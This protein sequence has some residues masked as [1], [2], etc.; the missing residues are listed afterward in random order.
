MDDSEQPVRRPTR[1]C[2]GCRPRLCA[3][4][5][6]R[7]RCPPWPRTGRS[8]PRRAAAP[9]KPIEGIRIDSVLDPGLG[10]S[11]EHLVQVYPGSRRGSPCRRP[12]RRIVGGRRLDSPVRQPVGKQPAR[13]FGAVDPSRS[14]DF[15]HL[16]QQFAL[17]TPGSPAGARCGRHR[18][19]SSRSS[20]DQ[21]QQYVQVAHDQ[22]GQA[23]EVAYSVFE[24]IRVS[25]ASKEDFDQMDGPHSKGSGK[26]RRLTLVETDRPGSRAPNARASSSPAWRPELRP[27]NSPAS[28]CSRLSRSPREGGRPAAPAR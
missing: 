11:I 10:D 9:T 16:V 15:I 3:P 6:V 21:V 25:R 20:F 4:G 17:Q 14:G 24:H 13:Q 18:S 8:G 26:P 5:R 12:T 7:A 27:A 22:V 19:G 23:C 28:C 2:G 1:S